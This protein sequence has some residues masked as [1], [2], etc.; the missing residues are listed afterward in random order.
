M[1]ETRRVPLV[2]KTVV[3]GNEINMWLLKT[4]HGDGRE[5]TSECIPGTAQ[6]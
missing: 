3:H 5:V 6:K 4:Q 2:L 1:E